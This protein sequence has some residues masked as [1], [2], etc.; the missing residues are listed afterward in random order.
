MSSGCF[1]NLLFHRYSYIK[2]QRHM[3]LMLSA[4]L[5][6]LPARPQSFS[7]RVCFKKT[8]TE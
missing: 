1:E 5:Y 3:G 8:H 7:E 2:K 4:F 6:Y